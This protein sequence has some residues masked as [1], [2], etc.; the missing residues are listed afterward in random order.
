MERLMSRRPRMFDVF[1]PTGFAPATASACAARN[2]TGNARMRLFRRPTPG[3]AGDRVV[4][5]EW[6]D[7]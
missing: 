7:Q 3:F 2:A 1:A 5:Q 6:Q 4:H